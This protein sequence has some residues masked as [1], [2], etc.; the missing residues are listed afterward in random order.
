VNRIIFLSLFGFRN[1]E[2]V[3]RV[4]LYFDFPSCP[5]ANSVQQINYFLGESLRDSYLETISSPKK[6]LTSTLLVH[7]HFISCLTARTKALGTTLID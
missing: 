2:K 1:V 7:V 4:F 3:Y 5:F 6:I